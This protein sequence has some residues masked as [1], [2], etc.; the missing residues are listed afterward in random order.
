MRMS[1]TK[2][3]VMACYFNPMG[4]RRRRLIFERFKAQMENYPNVEFWWVE[5]HYPFMQLPSQVYEKDNPRSFL[6]EM[7]DLYWAKETLLNFLAKCL[8]N[9]GNPLA[10]VD[11][12]IFFENPNWVNETLEKLDGQY[13]IVQLAEYYRDL[14]PNGDEVKESRV[15]TY[16]AK[17]E[18]FERGTHVVGWHGIGWAATRDVWTAMSGLIDFDLIGFSDTFVANA[19]NG[20]IASVIP[21]YVTDN[22]ETMLL[23]YEDDLHS[24]MPMLRAGFVSGTVNQPFHGTRGNR[25]YTARMQIWQRHRWDPKIDFTRNRYGIATIA[26]GIERRHAI[27]M[28]MLK[29]F[30]QRNED[31]F[32]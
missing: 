9:D 11:A 19:I 12:D 32:L 16:M 25:Q 4:Y 17:L 31:Q 28:A 21:P 6:V 24:A 23:N 15:L 26:G 10:W 29:Y 27:N 5:G 20:T 2:L 1:H 22:F 13:D 3:H 14:H 7:E 18:M 8:P 30:Q